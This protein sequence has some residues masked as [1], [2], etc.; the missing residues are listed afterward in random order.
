MA[1]SRSCVFGAH[2][3]DIEI[4]CGGTI[5]KLLQAVQENKRSLVVFS[6]DEQRGE[7]AHESANTFLRQAESKNIVIKTFTTSF[8]PYVGTDIKH[9]F[10]RLKQEVSP[11]VIFTHYRNDLHQDHRVISELTWNSFRDHLILRVRNPEVRR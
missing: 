5:L 4:G 1:R 2:C 11:D 3:D 6:S 10:E 7:E 8:F 9:I